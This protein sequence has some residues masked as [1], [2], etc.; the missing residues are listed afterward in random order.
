M[1]RVPRPV[2]A[3]LCSSVLTIRRREGAK[4]ECGDNPKAPW[5][6]RGA[7]RK[8]AGKPD[9]L[10]LVELQLDGGVGNPFPNTKVG[11][12]ERE[13]WGAGACAR[14]HASVR[15]RARVCVCVCARVSLGGGEECS[16]PSYLSKRSRTMKMQKASGKAR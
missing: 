7:R 4:E 12:R 2:A 1:R 13:R 9:P 16:S 10:R 5:L 3:H 6:L 8:S 11:R 14:E 15:V